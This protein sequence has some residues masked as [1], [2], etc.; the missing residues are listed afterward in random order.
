[1]DAIE[2]VEELNEELNGKKGLFAKKPDLNR[3][4]ELVAELN[5]TLPDELREAQAI[6]NQ[7]KSILENADTV[8]KN[9]IRTAEEKSR[10]IVSQSVMIREAEDERN[11]I[12]EN[13]YAQC[14]A[15]IARTKAHLDDMFREIEEFLLS[16]VNM[17]RKNR[18]ELRNFNLT[19]KNNVRK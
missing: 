9:T 4:A 8:A 3:L 7:R 5:T 11:K 18:E 17:V 6:N 10:Q 13:G 12:I 16:N 15:L 1:M 14:D 2:I 19:P